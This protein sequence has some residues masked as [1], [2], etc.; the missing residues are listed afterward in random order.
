MTDDEAKRREDLI[1]SLLAE[2]D[3]KIS[4]S[5]AEERIRSNVATDLREYDYERLTPD[6]AD[7]IAD[8]IIERETRK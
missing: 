2:Y 1:E 3:W 7:R 6:A 4:R 5:E 8:K